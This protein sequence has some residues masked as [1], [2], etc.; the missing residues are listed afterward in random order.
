MTNDIVGPI[1]TLVGIGVLAY[2]AKKVVDYL[3]EESG[4][5]KPV[6]AVKTKTVYTKPKKNDFGFNVEDK[7]GRI[8]G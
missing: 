7:I 1:G 8:L 6:R 5:K 3:A 4:K 2:G